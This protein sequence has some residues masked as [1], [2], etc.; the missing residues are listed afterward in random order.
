MQGSRGSWEFSF[1]ENARRLLPFGHKVNVDTPKLRRCG[2]TARRVSEE[3]VG[4]GVGDGE[5]GGVLE[6]EEF[7]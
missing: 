4:D 1:D 5:A 3:E 7:A 6:P 2:L